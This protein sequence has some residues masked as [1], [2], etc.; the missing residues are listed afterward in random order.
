M[1][2]PDP[3]GPQVCWKAHGSHMDMPPNTLFL[4]KLGAHWRNIPMP[5]GFPGFPGD[6]L[7]F[8][9]SHANKTWGYKKRSKSHSSSVSSDPSP[10]TQSELSSPPSSEP[11]PVPDPRAAAHPL[12]PSQ[13]CP[14]PIP[15]SM[16]T[17]TCTE[18]TSHWDP[19]RQAS[20]RVW[21]TLCPYLPSGTTVPGA[22]S[23]PLPVPAIFAPFA[24]HTG[25]GPRPSP[26]LRSAW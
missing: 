13:S 20:P 7:R 23:P 14:R 19:S 22:C 24:H 15:L 6:S 4:R 1:R 26:F 8:P 3:Q 16:A 10:Q 18:L 12:G 2:P 11:Q 25:P 17:E 21:V 5:T 9:G